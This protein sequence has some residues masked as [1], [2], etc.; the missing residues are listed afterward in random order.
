M[1]DKENKH[2]SLASDL[3]NEA[4]RGGYINEKDSPALYGFVSSQAKELGIDIQKEGIKVFITDAP[5]VE[6]RFKIHGD[7]KTLSLNKELFGVRPDSKPG[8]PAP[9]SIGA[10]AGNI[11]HELQHYKDYKDGHYSFGSQLKEFIA[12]GGGI[13]S[14]KRVN[15]CRADFVSPGNE[16]YIESHAIEAALNGEGGDNTH[17]KNTDRVKALIIQSYIKEK[18]GIELTPDDVKFNRNCEF[19]ITN[20]EKL[21]AIPPDV[22]LDAYNISEKK[23]KSLE[24]LAQSPAEDFRKIIMAMEEIR[25]RDMTPSTTPVKPRKQAVDVSLD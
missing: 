15:E 5:I 23:A 17:P 16:A 21:H 24:D 22:L 9:Y 10:V 18:T 6:A 1:P 14:Q 12:S 13:H 2:S 7:N 11:K 20:K 4:L 3:S 8:H 25:A 19:S